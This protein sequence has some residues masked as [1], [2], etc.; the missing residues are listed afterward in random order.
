MDDRG[1][2]LKEA[3]P[4]APVEVLGLS[5]VPG[6]GEK[7]LAAENE[8]KAR[9]ISEFRRRK[10][11]ERV[12]GAATAQRGTI[13]QMLQNPQAGEQ[14]EIAV[15]VKADVQGSVEAISATLGKLGTEEV[16][17]RV[18]HA[19]VGAITESDITLAKAS[20]ALIVAFNVRAVPQA[21]DM[22]TRDG[23]DIRYYSII[24]QVADDIEALVKGKTAPTLREK[25]LGYAEIRE[26]F[27]IT[28]VGKV[29]GCMVTEGV[30]KRGAGVRVLRDRTV[31][32]TGKLATLK[33][34]KEDVREVQKGFE[35]GLNLE[36]FQDIAKGDM[37]ECYETEEVAAA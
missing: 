1:R 7:C 27:T 10:E 3:G 35:C 22:A 32:H 18:L 21:R 6:A 36:N 29:A 13:E 8:T 12:A 28:K 26:V 14:K 33:R 34:F 2:Q 25:F 24:Y 31:I 9:E 30:I 19:A 17:V 11:R 37:I 20:G 16:R 4:A 5:G 23:V 15:L